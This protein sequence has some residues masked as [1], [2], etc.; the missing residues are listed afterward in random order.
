MRLVCALRD[1]EFPTAEEALGVVLYDIVGEQGV[2]SAGAA[3]RQQIAKDKVVPA[4]RAWD[5][6]SLALSVT[7]ADLASHRN[8][9][10]DGWTRDFA[11]DVATSD[12]AFWN[13]QRRLVNQLLAFLT[14]DRWQ[15]SFAGNGFSP[16]PEKAPVRP[17]EDCVVLLSGGLDSLVGAIDIVA[18]GKRPLAVSQTV[19][20][21]ATKQ[22]M[23]AQALGGGL[24]HLQVNHNVQVP[25][26]EDPPSQRARSLIFLAYGVLAATTLEMYGD[27]AKLPLYVCENGFISINPP[28]TAARLGSLS[29]RT[30]HPEFIRLVQDLLDAAGLRVR[31][32]NPYQRTTKGEMLRD[33]KDQ[34]FLRAHAASS[35][36]CGRFKKFG[37]T[38]CG[39][40]VPCLV[41]RAAF[42]KWGV[43][44]DTEYVYCVLG[45]DDDEHAG[46]DDVRSVAMAI[47]EVQS[48]GIRDWIGTAL[49]TATLDDVATLEEMVGRGLQELDS[50]L[51]SHGVE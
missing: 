2:G 4:P 12:P 31:I 39:R 19:R 3:I 29:T 6:L 21:D 45:Q 9:S 17:S 18:S 43:K 22:R 30:T 34:A 10:P 51:N 26:P 35:T 1:H 15:V 42:A 14:T 16:V 50:L 33:C 37:Y 13:G 28:L 24:R 27:R 20:G 36:S 49:S 7:A 38:H 46:F 32:T 48:G 25:D 11:L 40:C 5:L 23:F 47:Q 8:E 41:R 44:D